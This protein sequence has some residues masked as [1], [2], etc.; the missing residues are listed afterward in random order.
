MLCL[1]RDGV[2]YCNV[3]H[4]TSVLFCSPSES[5]FVRLQYPM[6]AGSAAERAEAG[7]KAAAKGRGREVCF[8]QSPFTDTVQCY[9]V[10]QDKF[11][12]I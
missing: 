10:K 9:R 8:L 11:E 12:L 6:A 5:G 4:E 3:P 2:K 1:M 7:G